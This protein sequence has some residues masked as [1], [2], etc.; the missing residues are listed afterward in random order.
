MPNN[1]AYDPR[2]TLAA[3]RAAQA[4]GL[5]VAKVASG[6]GASSYTITGSGFGTKQ[7]Y[8][9]SFD[10]FDNEPLGA[11]ANKTVGSLVAA[12]TSGITLEDTARD[13]GRCLVNDYAIT[14]FPKLHKVLSTTGKIGYIGCWIKRTIYGTIT[15]N[16]PVWKFS[17]VGSGTVYSGVPKVL[18]TSVGSGSPLTRAAELFD[19]DGV[20]IG[21]AG[22]YSVIDYGIVYPP[23]TWI[24]YELEYDYGT[25]GNADCFFEFRANGSIVTAFYGIDGFIFLKAGSTAVPEWLLTP[26]NGMGE[27]HPIKVWLDDVYIDESRARAV[28]TDAALY[29]N[30]TKWAVQPIESF[31]DTSVTVTGKRQDFTAGTSAYLHL[32]DDAGVL[33]SEGNAVTVQGDAV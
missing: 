5:R 18:D 14:G 13:G 33:V 4:V 17:R 20:G 2:V 12:F 25:P 28:L 8:T 15:G 31:S 10:D 26:I 3:D 29:V 22:V 21:N 30:S 1:Q 11:I 24:F 16:T 6:G 19:S 9:P 27:Y 32:F 7:P 23:D